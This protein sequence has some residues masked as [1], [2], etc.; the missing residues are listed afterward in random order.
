MEPTSQLTGENPFPTGTR[1]GRWLLPVFAVV[2]SFLLSGLFILLTRTNPL[3]GYRYLLTAGFGCDALQRCALLTTLQFATPLLLTGL[4][5]TV[6]FRVG[7]F[8][9]GQAGQCCWGAAAPG[10]RTADIPPLA[11]TLLALCAESRP[12]YGDG[13]RC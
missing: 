7:L 1:V 6:A 4:S 11:Q 8:S 9:I 3:D 13:F 5:A 2:A 10:W 12:G